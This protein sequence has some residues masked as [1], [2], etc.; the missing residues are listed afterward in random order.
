MKNPL[1][2][3]SQW[4]QKELTH[5]K[6]SI[7]SACCLST[8]GE[9]GY[10][11]SRFISLKEIKDETFIITGSINSRKGKEINNTPKVSLTFWWAETERQVRIQGNAIIISE[12]EAEEY[13]LKRSQDSKVVSTVFK[14]GEEIK[15]IHE[16]KTRFNK[17]KVKLENEYIQKPV[18]WAGLGINPIRIEFMEFKK[19]RLHERILFIKQ[20]RIWRKVYLQP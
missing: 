20:D 12:P 2:I 7:P 11:N 5:S 13:F 10:P 8:I 18:Q 15:S 4:Y 6:V 3:F 9:D 14:Q 1:E 17:A 16:L 19:T